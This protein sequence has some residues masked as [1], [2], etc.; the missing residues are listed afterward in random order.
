ME[1]LD[2]DNKE[3]KKTRIES[4]AEI[5]NKDRKDP[6]PEER[7]KSMSRKEKLSY[8]KEYYLRYTI[9]ALALIILSIYVI[10]NAFRPDEPYVLFLGM[11]D[12]L[13]FEETLVDTIDK[14]FGAYLES[15]NFEGE[16][17]Q[18]RIFFETFYD[19][20]VD[21]TRI[22][23]FYDRSQF[24]VL[25]TRDRSFKP[26]AEKHLFLNLNE[27]LPKDLLDALSDKLVYTT[28]TDEVPSY[29]CGIKIQ[30]AAYDMHV[31]T[32]EAVEDDYVSIIHNAQNIEA[33]VEFIRFLYGIHE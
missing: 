3:V 13:Q 2:N 30:N 11:F 7:W 26:F 8:Y 1:L 28:T 16:V 18:D 12:G 10:V 31:S 33:S 5:Y 19:T 14:D 21:N 15:S 4:S 22:D 20:I 23:G 25:I 29:P 6:S 24:D 32:G 17:I 9:I 27:V